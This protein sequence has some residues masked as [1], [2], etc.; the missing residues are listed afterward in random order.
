MHGSVKADVLYIHVSVCL[1]RQLHAEPVNIDCS[2]MRH[3]S[4]SAPAAEL[5]RQTLY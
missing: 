5:R 3:E 4:S 2:E 1:F